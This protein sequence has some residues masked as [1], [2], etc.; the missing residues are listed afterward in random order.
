MVTTALYS[1]TLLSAI[2]C[3]L[4]LIITFHYLEIEHQLSRFKYFLISCFIMKMIPCLLLFPSSHSS[5]LI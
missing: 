5:S 1:F 3:Y 2:K 4:I